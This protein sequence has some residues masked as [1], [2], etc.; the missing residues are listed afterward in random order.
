MGQKKSK[1]SLGPRVWAALLTFGLIGQVAWVVENMYF[2]VFLYNTIT[3]DTKAI[4]AMVAA[5]AIVAAVTT[6][7]VGA[8]SDKLGK[9]KKII[10]SGYLLWG[11]SV[12]AFA[13]VR[14]SGLAALVG[15]AKAVQAAAVTVIVLDCVMT[16][17]GSSANDAAFNAWVTDVTTDSNRG[18]VEAVLAIMPLVAMLVVFGALDGLTAQGNWTAFFL[19]V[20]ALTMLGGGLGWLLIKEPEGIRPAGGNYFAN[21]FYG[22]RPG[23]IWANPPLYLALAALAVYS[24]SQQVYMP[25]LIIYIQRY[26]GVDNY[27]L[28]LGTVLIAASAVSVACGRIIDRKGK[29]SVAVPAAV[30][31]F[32]GLACMFFVRSMLPVILAGTLMLGASMVLSACLQGLIRDYTPP[33]KAGQFQGIRILFQVLLPMVTGPYIGSAVIGHSGQTYEDLGVV[34]EVPTPEIFLASALV[35]LLIAVPVAL[36]QRREPKRTL[37]RRVLH[38][39]LTVWGEKLDREHPLPEYPRPQLR[40][41]SYLNLNGPWQYAIRPKGDRQPKSFDSEIV[42][43]FSPESLLSGVQRILLPEERLWYRRTFTLPEGFR[44]DRVLLHFGAADQSCEVSVNGKSVGGHEG[45]YLPFTCDITDAL[46]DGGNTLVVSV[47]DATSRSRHAYGKQ[48]FTPGGIWYTPQSGIWQTVWLESVPENYVEKLTITPLYDDRQVRLVIHAKDPEGANAVVRKD[49]LVIAEDWYDEAAGELVLSIMDEHFRPWSPEDPFL[50]DVTVTLNSGDRV[51]SYF[52]MRKFGVTTVDKKKVLALN[53]KPVFMSGVLDQGY[54]S[55]GLYT[56]A[57]DEAM[58]HDIQTMKDCGFNMLRKH[59]KIE[60]LRWYYHCDRLGMLVWQDL[61]SGG[62]RIDPLVVQILPFLGCNLQDGRYHRFGREDPGSREQFIQDLR[63]TV[64]HLYNVPSLA[65][66]VPFNEGWG[67]FDSLRATQLLW[68]LDPTRLVDHASGWH[69]QGGG[70]FKSRHVYF[71][72]VRIKHDGSRVLALSE[73]GGYSLPEAGHVAS[74]K[75]F[76]YR[77]YQDRGSFMDAFVSLYEK[78]VLPCMER[79]GLSAAVYTQVSDVED[80]INGLLTYDR[81]VCKVDTERVRK[82]NAKLKFPV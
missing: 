21:I 68:D 82:V 28:I 65:V 53:G 49:G 43:P 13:F 55:D 78:E 64:D 9:R 70:D 11:L 80:E 4:A 18:R 15:P 38:P 69:D 72:P 25:Y 2:N 24:A 3:G 35:L 74:G 39:L 47:T 16:F 40:R 29:L 63:G 52:A 36:L 67:Q 8:L 61:V 48:S 14:V 33:A 76:G 17:F 19:I 20:G 51:E 26:L 10:V 73:F 42:V 62:S 75:P 27:A 7:V 37:S 66:W 41:D 22:L 59:I 1:T 57:S 60:P 34:K 45:G 44:K 81:K 58:I 31:A 71:K 56:P 23:V 12:M 5:S 54:W 77:M 79:Q 46:L 32:V 50:Y 6:L 30:A